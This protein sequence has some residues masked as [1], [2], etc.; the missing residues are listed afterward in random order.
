MAKGRTR[1]SIIGAVRK[2]PYPLRKTGPRFKTWKVPETLPYLGPYS[3]L[4]ARLLTKRL[5]QLGYAVE[6]EVPFFGGRSVK[7]GQVADIF[8][9]N[10]GNNGTVVRVQGEYWHRREGS[11][12]RDDA[13]SLLLM[14]RGIRVVDVWENDIKTR[15]SWVIE[16][17]IGRR[18]G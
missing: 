4:V 10:M 18:V 17:L 8:I 3:S 15:L 9:R 14:S 11:E 2:I 7:G 1:T 6:A 16:Q 5:M 12:A 13:Q